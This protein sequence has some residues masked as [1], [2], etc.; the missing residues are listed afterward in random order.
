LAAIVLLLAPVISSGQ[1]TSQILPNEELARLYAEHEKRV[2][3]QLPPHSALLPVLDL[4][5]TN[6]DSPGAGKKWED[7]FTCSMGV[8]S[9]GDP[10]VRSPNDLT[11]VSTTTTEYPGQAGPLLIRSCELIVIGQP[12]NASAHLAYNR[13]FVYSAYN[14]KI[15]ELLKGNRRDLRAG[16][17]LNV[18]QLGGSIR[19]PSGHGA[20]FWEVNEGFMTLNNQYL[21]FL[22]KPVPSSDTYMVAEEYLLQDGL[23]FP[24]M[25]SSGEARYS[26]TPADKFVA[27]VKALIAANKDG[28]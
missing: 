26:N 25:L 3:Q 20:F 11:S 28:M 2:L 21:L 7:R 8:R 22:W 16:K 6:E 27:R 13:R 18:A 10:G 23:V 14:I 15:L 1:I 12:E 4:S 17:L 9:I 5:K 24:I 19:F